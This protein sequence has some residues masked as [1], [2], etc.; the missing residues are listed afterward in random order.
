MDRIYAAVSEVQDRTGMKVVP[1]IVT[2]EE[3]RSRGQLGDA[4]RAGQVL[5][6]GP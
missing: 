5:Y 6:E 2:P 4:L 1:M 3:L